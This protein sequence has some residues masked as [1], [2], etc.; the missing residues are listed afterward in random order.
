M[1]CRR[2]IVSHI[3]LLAARHKRA[4]P[5]LTSASKPGTRFTYLGGME[6]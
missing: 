5:A 6:G 1:G 2:S 3:I 4:Q